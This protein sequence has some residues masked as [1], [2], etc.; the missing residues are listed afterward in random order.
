MQCYIKQ[1]VQALLY[2]HGSDITDEERLAVLQSRLGGDWSKCSEVWSV[3]DNEHILRIKATSGHGTAPVT[4]VG[5]HDDV[6]EMVG[7]TFKPHLS[8]VENVL[9]AVFGKI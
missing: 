5:N 9:P 7:Q 1:D 6:A 4:A 3:A 2:A 8:P